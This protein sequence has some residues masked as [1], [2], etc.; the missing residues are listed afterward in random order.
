M[1]EC[2]SKKHCKVTPQHCSMASL[3]VAI[4]MMKGILKE[5]AYIEYMGTEIDRDDRDR[6]RDRDRD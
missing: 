2:V 3:W 1:C 6:D 4:S 5:Y